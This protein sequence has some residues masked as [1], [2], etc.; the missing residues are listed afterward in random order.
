VAAGRDRVLEFA[1]QFMKKG[2]PAPQDETASLEK[3]KTSRVEEYVRCVSEKGLDA[4]VEELGQGRAEN[5]GAY[6]FSPEEALQQA[7]QFLAC[8]QHAEAIGL[9]QALRKDYPKIADSYA[10]L[11][12]AYLGQGDVPAA[13]AVLKDGEAVEAM[14]TWE[15]PRIEKAKNALRKAQFGSAAALLGKALSEGGIPAAEEQWRDL[16]ERRPDGPVFEENE[17]NELGYRLLGENQKESAVFVMEK[18]VDLFPDSWNAWD[19]LGE[20]AAKAG[21]KEKAI[22]G[23]RRSLELNPQN[24]DGRAILEKLEKRK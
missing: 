17:F 2:D 16:L 10:T 22:A 6:Y 15:R 23:Y 5:G 19:S 13:E 21:L 9:L 14:F 11:A 1:M 20:A 7:V 3:V 12:L 18:M 4:A 24:K 8:Q